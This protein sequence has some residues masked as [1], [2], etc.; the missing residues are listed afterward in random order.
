MQFHVMSL[1][2]QRNS[3]KVGCAIRREN[4]GNCVFLAYAF[5]DCSHF[6]APAVFP[7][8]EMLIPVRA[9]CGRS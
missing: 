4:W 3:S 8:Q 1:R 7:L 2:V 9:D 5:P 6:S